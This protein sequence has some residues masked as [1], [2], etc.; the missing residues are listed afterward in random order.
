MSEDIQKLEKA[1]SRTITPYS[2]NIH[3]LYLEGALTGFLLLI[4]D[5]VMVPFND[6]KCVGVNLEDWIKLKALGDATITPVRIVAKGKGLVAKG[7]M[8]HVGLKHAVR[9]HDGAAM[10]HIPVAEF[11]PA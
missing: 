8:P 7:F 5:P 11:K 4:T 6:Q 2:G 10:L 9:D 1:W 3:S